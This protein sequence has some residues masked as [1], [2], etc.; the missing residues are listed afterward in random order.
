M[1]D[2]ICITFVVALLALSLVFSCLSRAL[3]QND[4]PLAGVFLHPEFVNTDTTRLY[5]I[6]VRF[7]DHQRVDT[8]AL[9]P[10][11][12]Y[13]ALDP[14]LLNSNLTPLLPATIYHETV[15]TLKCR[16]H[17]VVDNPT[18]AVWGFYTSHARA[19]SLYT[20]KLNVAFYEGAQLAHLSHQKS[21]PFFQREI[22]RRLLRNRNRPEAIQS[23]EDGAYIAG[24][25][26]ALFPGNPN[27]VA[28][29]VSIMCFGGLF[30]HVSCLVGSPRLV[31]RILP[32][33][34][35]GDLVKMLGDDSTAVRPFDRYGAVTELFHFFVVS[36]HITPWYQL[37]RFPF[38]NIFKGKVAL[39]CDDYS[40]AMTCFGRNFDGHTFSAGVWFDSFFFWSK[41]CILRD[42]QKGVDRAKS[43]LDDLTRT[44]EL[45]AHPEVATKMTKALVYPEVIT[46]SDDR[47]GLFDLRPEGK[48]DAVTPFL[49]QVCQRISVSLEE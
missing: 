2:R 17:I 6:S 23:Y 46:G 31:N 18:A 34:E 13:V 14:I 48:D 40:E 43:L 29:A 10:H 19:G 1:Q 33:L 20:R 25:L 35:H 49:M 27:A 7:S 45:A 8:K 15:H 38:Y 21:Y 12:V 24:F 30:E 36:Q 16:E 28:N 32:V 42:G 26:S 3:Q 9:D 41:A 37:E 39:Y 47:S 4:P 44:T 22:N 5:L 11:H